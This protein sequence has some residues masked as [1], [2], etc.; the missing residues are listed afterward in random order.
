MAVATL[1]A[2]L[3]AVGLG[4]AG[5]ILNS[6]AEITLFGVVTAL[7]AWAAILPGKLWE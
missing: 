6:Q 5:D 3:I 2:G 7:G 4:A 1:C